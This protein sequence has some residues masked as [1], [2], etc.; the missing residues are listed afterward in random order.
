[1][2]IAFDAA[3]S[4]GLDGSS[5][6]F[7]HSCS[8][9]NR[10]LFFFALCHTGGAAAQGMASVTY[11]GIALTKL[12]TTLTLG[13]AA[14]K[15]ELWYLSNPAIGSNTLAW[16]KT[17]N[18]HHALM[19]ISY[20]GVDINNPIGNNGSQTLNASGD[21]SLNITSGDGEM[22][23]DFVGSNDGGWGLGPATHSPGAGQTERFDFQVDA[24][25]GNYRHIAGSEEPGAASV[26]MSYA[27]VPDTD[28]G[29]FAQAIKPAP[30]ARRRLVKYLHNSDV[31]RQADR[32][33]VHDVLGRDVPPEQ[34]QPEQW[35][36]TDGPYFLTSDK[37]ASLISDPR[38]QYIE[39]I[40]VRGDQVDIVTVRESLLEGLLQRLSRSG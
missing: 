13:G 28:L 27:V 6:S 40:G 16:S 24:G 31:S 2:A 9:A 26:T 29:Y 15:L 8:G 25:T 21:P 22:V 1:M 30:E 5:G 7:A 33:V 37:P 18:N 39:S 38:A 11:G 17:N 35:M 19:A 34:I 14:S 12:M 36:Y 32:P 20:T 23:L 4:N 3:T 10:I